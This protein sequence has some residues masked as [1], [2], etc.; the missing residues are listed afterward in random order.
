MG[1]M[2]RVWESKREF[3]GQ[4]QID[5]YVA[6]ARRLR[7]TRKLQIAISHLPA[8]LFNPPCLTSNRTRVVIIMIR[9][10]ISYTCGNL[11]NGVNGDAMGLAV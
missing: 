5:F 10:G 1:H 2:R 9:V 6:E 3:V 4:Q 7:Y 11:Y 8:E